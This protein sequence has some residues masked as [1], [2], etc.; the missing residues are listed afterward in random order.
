[1]NL[2][3]WWLVNED[4]RNKEGRE[5]LLHYVIYGYEVASSMPKKVVMAQEQPS[6]ENCLNE[7]LNAGCQMDLQGFAQKDPAG[8]QRG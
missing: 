7:G 2:K 3:S 6:S 8:F 4:D 1:M 5:K